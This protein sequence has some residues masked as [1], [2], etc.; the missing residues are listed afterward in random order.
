MTVERNIEATTES[1]VSGVMVGG[2]PP[3][4]TNNITPGMRQLF[5][6]AV[7]SYII[8]PEYDRIYNMTCAPSN[9]SDQPAYSYSLFGVSLGVQ[10]IHKGPILIVQDLPCFDSYSAP[11]YRN[12]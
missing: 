4:V 1:G 7:I 6:T 11:V 5:I 3:E 2:C 9:V 8:V 12:F 10:F